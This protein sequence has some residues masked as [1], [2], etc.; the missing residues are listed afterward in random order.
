MNNCI[1]CNYWYCG[2][3][4]KTACTCW[5]NMSL[6]R[7][8]FLVCQRLWIT[9]LWTKDERVKEILDYM[10]SNSMVNIVNNT[11]EHFWY[12][13]PKMIEEVEN[14]QISMM[15]QYSSESWA[16]RCSRCNYPKWR[17]DAY[18]KDEYCKALVA[19]E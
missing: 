6:N 7:N 12:V 17:K 14:Q 2:W 8:A 15:C 16:C 18:A 11:L 4:W 3:C 1:Y 5:S 9:N 10:K 19:K 13:I